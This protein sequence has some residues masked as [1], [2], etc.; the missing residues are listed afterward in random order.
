MAP[1]VD[2]LAE[3]KAKLRKQIAQQYWANINRI[4]EAKS[5]QELDVL[6]EGGKYVA[7]AQGLPARE[8]LAAP[9]ISQEVLDDLQG[10]K[11]F[12]IF[13]CTWINNQGH[14]RDTV[15]AAVDA[16]RPLNVREHRA[17]GHAFGERLMESDERKGVFFIAPS[18]K[19][20]DGG[21]TFK[22][23]SITLQLP[24]TGRMYYRLHAAKVPLQKQAAVFL[25][26]IEVA[27]D[28]NANVDDFSHDRSWRKYATYEN[29]ERSKPKP[30][31][32][33]GKGAVDGDFWLSPP[34]GNDIRV[35]VEQE[36]KEAAPGAGMPVLVNGQLIF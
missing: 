29:V 24:V 34:A 1:K 8:D 30:K 31:D 16:D 14:Q 7:W 25:R 13:E 9:S 5:A 28:P 15:F 12:V 36:R 19:R 18:R 3:E 26:C 35:R 22:R 17:L 23:T 10:D 2:K 4:R 11:R 21:Y 20:A 33:S 27:A 32:E 6:Q